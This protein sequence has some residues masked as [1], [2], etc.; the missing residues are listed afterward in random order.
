MNTENKYFKYKMKYLQYKMKQLV[1]QTGGGR[2]EYITLFK[3]KID[4]YNHLILNKYESIGIDINII[5]NEIIVKEDE[6]INNIMKY[7]RENIKNTNITDIGSYLNIIRGNFEI[8]MEAMVKDKIEEANPKIDTP[9]DKINEIIE[10]IN[11]YRSEIVKISYILIV[12]NDKPSYFQVLI[13]TSIYY[14]SYIKNYYY[15]KYVSLTEK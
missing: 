12:R 11:L 5:M 15:A 2:K 1:K 13:Y 6:F 9:P 8:V 3:N 7:L 10:E 14:Y 4:Y